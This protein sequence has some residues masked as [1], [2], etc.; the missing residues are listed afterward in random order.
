MLRD[1]IE[2]IQNDLRS[3]R[4]TNEAAVSQGIV[5]PV[6]YELGWPVFDTRSVAPEYALEGRR[7]DFAL[8]DGSDRP[9]VFLEVKRVG[10]AEGRDR[11]L[12]EYAFHRGVPV[13]ILT[14]GQEWSFYLPGEEG[15]YE[16]RRVYK[17][18]LLERDATECN[19]RLTRYLGHMR[20]MSGEALEAAHGL[21][22][23]SATQGRLPLP[24]PEPGA[25]SLRA[26]I[27]CSSSCW[28]TR[29]KTCAGTSL[30]PI[31]APDS[32]RHSQP[33]GVRPR[34]YVSG[35]CLRHHAAQAESPCSARPRPICLV[36]SRFFLPG[37]FLP[38]SLGKRGDAG[39]TPSAGRSRSDLSGSLHCPQA[40]QEATI[41]S[42]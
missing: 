22:G 15:H 8:C 33:P 21:S 37:E 9:K 40:R 12:F 10:Q 32:F 2:Q 7:V 3:G 5:L 18:D 19:D 26:K 14:D 28:P 41:R 23:R 27:L 30:T 1:V 11:Q 25:L 16:E 6:L 39:S 24:C 13:A 4:F 17:I 31:H 29:S 20:V 36:S 34:Q 38:G 35:Q 42:A